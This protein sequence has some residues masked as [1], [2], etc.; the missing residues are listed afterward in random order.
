MDCELLESSHRKEFSVLAK[1]ISPPFLTIC[2]RN[3]VSLSIIVAVWSAIEQFMATY[4]GSHL[5]PG[6]ASIPSLSHVNS[7][8]G[9]R[10]SGSGNGVVIW[11]RHEVI[12][13]VNPSLSQSGRTLSNSLAVEASRHL[14]KLQSLDGSIS[15]EQWCSV[16]NDFLKWNDHCLRL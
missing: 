16:G 7:L 9:G 2:R 12:Q 11:P 13:L 15:F 4:G 14:A 3:D 5:G 8:T 1:E 10:I 6:S